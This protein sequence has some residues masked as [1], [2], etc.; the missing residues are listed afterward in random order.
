MN[1]EE[2][3][4][5]SGNVRVLFFSAARTLAGV[6]QTSIPCGEPLD[7]NGLWDKLLQAYPGLAQIRSQSRLALNGEFPQHG[8]PMG[9]GDEVAVIPPVSGG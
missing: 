5:S 2:K 9:P 6:A 1:S 7:E 3:S 8:D 4:E